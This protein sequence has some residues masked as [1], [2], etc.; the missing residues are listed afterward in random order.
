MFPSDRIDCGLT[1]DILEGHVKLQIALAEFEGQRYALAG[2][3][4]AQ[5]L[6]LL[7]PQLFRNFRSH[8][9]RV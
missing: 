7:S 9:E 5:I 8:H 1:V 3:Q 2:G 4:T 6:D